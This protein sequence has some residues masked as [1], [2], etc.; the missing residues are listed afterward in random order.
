MKHQKPLRHATAGI[1]LQCIAPL[2]AALASCFASGAQ[3]ADSDTIFVT[4]TRQEARSNELLSDVTVISREQIEQAGQTSIEQ[5]LAQQPGIE[6][7]ANGGPGSSSSVSIRGANSDHTVVLIDGQRFGSLMGGP[8]F[9]RLP[10]A[11]IERIEIL[12][13]PASSLYGADAIGGVIQIFTRRGEGPARI[14]ASTGYGSYGTSDS[15]LGVS[16][17]NETVSYSLQAGH[18]ETKGFSTV[19]NPQAPW[20]IYNADRD[21]FRNQSTSGS[22]A[23]R[24]A[25]GHEVGASFLLANGKSHY[26]DGA[27][28]DK[29]AQQDI[30]SVSLYSRNRLTS[31]WTSTL[32][33]GR[34]FDDSTNLNNGIAADVFHTRQD[35]ASWQNDIQ[36]PLGRA[37]I[38]TEYLKEELSATSAA[39]S[40]ERSVKSLLTGWNGSIGDNRLQFNLRHDDNSQFGGKTTGSAAYGYQFSPELRAGMSYGTAFKAPSFSHLYYPGYSNPNLKPENSRNAEGSVTWEKQGQRLSATYFHNKVEDLII[41]PP[42][43]Y[44]PS[45]VGKATLSGTSLAYRGSHGDFSGGV[46]IDLQRARDDDTGRRLAHR[47]DEQLKVHLAWTHGVTK[48]GG[49]WQAVGDRFNDATNRQRQGGYALLNLFVEQRLDREWT[50]FARANNIFDRDYEI[51]RD[52]GVPGASVFVGVRYQQK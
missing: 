1:T 44:L 35:Q 17:G 20:G 27:T 12:R 29:A 11:Q 23:I 45:N 15:T 39:L 48:L 5:L 2:A 52:Y 49:E 9:S 47:A 14:N 51:V 40:R 33:V 32:R 46:T 24:P 41:S 26:D 31:D 50:L 13:G 34:S 4:A 21:G 38:A 7:W 3:A 19:R 18:Y 42:P 28:N 37:L 30:G 36:L 10:L 43:T 25:A 6:F 8:D 16:G 22:L